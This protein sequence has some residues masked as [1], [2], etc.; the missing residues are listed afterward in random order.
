VDAIGG[1]FNAADVEMDL[2]S[3]TMD[4][5]EIGFTFNAASGT[6][7]LPTGS[8]SGGMTLNAAS[9][10]LCV[11]PDANLRIEHHGTLSSADFEGAGL[12]EVGD[13]WETPGFE[14]S[15]D[16]IDLSIS[17]TMSSITLDRSGSC[18]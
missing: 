1:T 15:A 9:L 17:T 14:G 8:L 12:V 6:L 2:S 7:R 3:A 5:A 16:Q 11:D 13:A 4:D 10:E 18:T